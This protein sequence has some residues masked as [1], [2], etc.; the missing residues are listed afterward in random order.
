MS[1]ALIGFIGVVAGILTGGGVQW[2]L[3]GRDRKREARVAAAMIFAD[4]AIA[5]RALEP[6]LAG[7]P[8]NAVRLD[9]YLERWQE[10]R[11]TL[12]AGVSPLEFHLITLAFKNLEEYIVRGV[13]VPPR[14]HALSLV[15]SLERGMKLTW[16]A[17][18]MKDD[19]KPDDEKP[20]IGRDGTDAAQ[21]GGRDGS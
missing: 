3:A 8:P 12:A 2:F 10:E 20:E 13:S 6:L 5:Y 14:L 17:S 18:G 11:R 7:N 16:R 19:D 15:E 1:S 4:L 21:E 9:R